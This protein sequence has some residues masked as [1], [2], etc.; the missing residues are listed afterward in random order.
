MLKDL[1]TG[2]DSHGSDPLFF[3]DHQKRPVDPN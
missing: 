3:L 1:A 2:F